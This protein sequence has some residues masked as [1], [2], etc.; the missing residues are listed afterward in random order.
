VLVVF[1]LLILLPCSFFNSVGAADEIDSPGTN[2]IDPHRYFTQEQIDR[3]HSYRSGGYILFAAEC[4][5]SFLF[6]ALLVFTGGSRKLERRLTRISGNSLTVSIILYSL[7]LYLVFSALLLPLSFYTSYIR[8]KNYGFATLTLSRWFSDYAKSLLIG[9]ILFAILMVGLFS[10]IRKFPR[11]WHIIAC[12]GFTLYVIVT[13]FIWPVIVDPLFHKFSPLADAGLRNELLS[14]AREAGIDAREVLVMD[15]SARTTHTN[16]YFTG[17]SS[18]K[19][20]VLYDTLL[21]AHSPSEIKVILAHEIGHWKQLHV[22]RGIVIA[23]AGALVALTLLRLFLLLA[24]RSY[25]EGGKLR[26]LRVSEIHA[27]SNLPLI[28]LFLFILGVFWLPVRNA[29]SRHFERQAD[30]ESLVLTGDADSFI[31]AEVKLAVD[32]ALDIAPPKAAYYFIY[33]HPSVLERIAAAEAFAERQ[34]KE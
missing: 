10:I 4:V 8:E 6:V 29:I 23:C 7:F 31:R 15:A 30:R 27:P 25:E 1:G 34:K 12:A 22:L 11:T 2:A 5:V 28:L 17:L 16:A 20:V 9:F 19:R 24:K 33:S 3:G 32:N 26:F 13:V 21:A 14:V 18:T